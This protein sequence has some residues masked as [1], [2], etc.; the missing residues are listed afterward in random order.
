MDS[1]FRRSESRSSGLLGAGAETIVPLS[2]GEAVVSQPMYGAVSALGRGHGGTGGGG[3]WAD[4]LQ[5]LPLFAGVPKRHVRKI[6]GLARE[7]RYRRGTTIVQAGTRGSDFFVIVD[8]AA[9][10]LRPGGLP[11]ISIGPGAYFGEMS[12]L[13]GGERSATVQAASDMVCLRLS[14]GPF[15]K[16]VRSEPQIAVALL[17]ELAG[18]VR[19][20]QAATGT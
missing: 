14:G 1:A 2:T 19:T 20:L 6:A 7:A 15:M 3:A 18:R 8:G 11:A 10:V 4:V 13:D 17:R 5:E 9:T 12:L 16:M